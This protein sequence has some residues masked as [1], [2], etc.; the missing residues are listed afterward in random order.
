[1]KHKLNYLLVN[2]HLNLNIIKYS[3]FITFKKLYIKAIDP[4]NDLWAYKIQIY[5][6]DRS[7]FSKNICEKLQEIYKNYI[8]DN[9]NEYLNYPQYN[10]VSK[11]TFETLIK[12]E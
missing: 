7:F 10:F 3:K 12:N 8:I 11:K 4:C 5:I 2:K 9:S 6:F 1:M